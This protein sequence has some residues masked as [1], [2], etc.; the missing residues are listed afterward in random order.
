MLLNNCCWLLDVKNI[1]IKNKGDSTLSH[2]ITDDYL[3]NNVLLPFLTNV[4]QVNQECKN[5]EHRASMRILAVR[6]QH[7]QLMIGYF[8]VKVSALKKK[9]RTTMPKDSVEFVF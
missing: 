6:K 1:E 8:R 5:S 9:K 3:P 7:N 4:M 2:L